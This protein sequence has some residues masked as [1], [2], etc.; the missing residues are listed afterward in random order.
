MEVIGSL[1]TFRDSRFWSL[2][3]DVYVYSLFN[4]GNI[5][6]ILII[7]VTLDSF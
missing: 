2:V 6:F 4:R 1:L 3:I 7:R 5:L